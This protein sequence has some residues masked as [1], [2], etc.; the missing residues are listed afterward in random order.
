MLIEDVEQFLNGLIPEGRF[1]DFLRRQYRRRYNPYHLLDPLVRSS[2]IQPDGTLL[3]EL[4]G[5]FRLRGPR[6]EFVYR[7]FRYADPARLKNTGHLGMW[8]IFLVVLSEEFGK[9]VYEMERS[10]KAGDTVLDV[11]AHIGGFTVRAARKVGPTGRVI[12]VEAAPTNYQLLE[13]NLRLNDLGNVTALNVGAWREPTTLTMHLSG[14]SGGHS[15]EE[16]YANIHESGEVAEVRVDTIDNLL[17]KQGVD[18]VDFVKMDIEG[19][20]IE[21]IKGMRRT[22]ERGDARLAIAAYHRVDGRQTHH[23]V[24][25]QLAE[26]GYRSRV[27]AGIV[28]ASRA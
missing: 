28:L 25:R 26:L 21:A 22:L 15:I 23:E 13:S 14:L 9:D 10:V 3:V 7:T 2:E 5:G 8:S 19:A 17:A 20:E 27:Q 18:R 24:T 1:K 4:E 6:D 16:R 12:A 11:G